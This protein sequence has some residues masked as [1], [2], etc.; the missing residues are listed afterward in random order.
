VK[1]LGAVRIRP[2]SKA[3][4]P[5]VIVGPQAQA[6]PETLEPGDVLLLEGKLAYKVGKTKDSGKLQVVA[7]AVER[8][9]TA[10]VVGV[11]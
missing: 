6:C 3:F 10:A 8:L 2:R 7:F 1:S 11:D 9:P 5:V 4:M